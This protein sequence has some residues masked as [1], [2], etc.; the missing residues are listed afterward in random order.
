M[1]VVITYIDE[2]GNFLTSHGINVDTLKN[3]V[4]PQEHPRNLGAI[5]DKD[6]GEW[7]IN[8]S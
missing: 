6:M 3:V 1:I 7:V 5:F 4:L 2:E 8:D